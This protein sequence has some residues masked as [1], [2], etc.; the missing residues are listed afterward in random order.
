[1][2]ETSIFEME[3]VNPRVRYTTKKKK[4]VRINPTLLSSIE[5]YEGVNALQI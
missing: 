1:M 3:E 5:P 2:P 4:I